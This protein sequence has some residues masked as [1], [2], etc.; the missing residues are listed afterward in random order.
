MVVFKNEKELVNALNGIS[1]RHTG[2]KVNI[3][4][5]GS[6]KEDPGLDKEIYKPE[7]IEKYSLNDKPSY[8]DALEDILKRVYNTDYQSYY[9]TY[10]EIM[11]V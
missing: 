8:Q 3:S 6:I 10:T 4:I 7:L 2:E 5:Y 1:S 9:W 11:E